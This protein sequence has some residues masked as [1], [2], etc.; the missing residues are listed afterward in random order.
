MMSQG[1]FDKEPEQ[2]TKISALGSA[3]KMEQLTPICAIN[4]FRFLSRL[5]LTIS[6]STGVIGIFDS[7]GE[8]SY[9]SFSGP[10][11]P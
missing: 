5:V 7:V 4:L 10:T 6:A 9:V 3:G 11:N 8:S 2:E 1:Q